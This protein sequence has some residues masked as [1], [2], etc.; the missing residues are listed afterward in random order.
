MNF[1]RAVAHWGSTAPERASSYPCDAVLP[2][3]KSL[4]RAVDVAAPVDVVY[5]WLCQLRLAPYSYDW[6][7]NFGKRS[8]R[9]L[10][11]GLERLAVGQRAMRVFSIVDFALNDHITVAT[12]TAGAKRI[13]GNV[14][15]TYRVIATD[16]GS[17]IIVS[18]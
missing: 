1:N 5:R 15:V 17:R 6:L 8:P 12:A 11:P 9:A 7:D 3:G 2:S 14:V 13:L 18:R 4:F 16:F 10:T